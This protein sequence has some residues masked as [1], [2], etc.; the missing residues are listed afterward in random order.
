MP[1]NGLMKKMKHSET[2]KC[3]GH[4]WKAGIA[5]TLSRLFWHLANTCV[6]HCYSSW[7]CFSKLD[8][9][10]PSIICERFLPNL[11]PSNILSSGDIQIFQ[12]FSRKATSRT[13]AHILGELWLNAELK[14]TRSSFAPDSRSFN[15]RKYNWYLYVCFSLCWLSKQEKISSI[16]MP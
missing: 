5:T 12:C 10:K 14:G 13:K 7:F 1:S 6:P 8:I 15:F 3:F 4:I 11:W 9:S 16:W 2:R